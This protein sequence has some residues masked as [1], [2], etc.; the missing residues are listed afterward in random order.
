MELNMETCGFWMSL[1][2]TA[3]LMIIY[4]LGPGDG[5]LEL[6]PFDEES[7]PITI[8]TRPDLAIILRCDTVNHR[9]VST[10]N[11]YT[12]CLWV[13]APNA[14]GP[15]GW[16]SFSETALEK[17]EV[18]KELSA[19][20]EKR[21][22]ALMQKEA[23][24]GL[25]EDAPRSWLRWMRATYFK[26]SN[27][28]VAIT[29]AATH[30]PG[31]NTCE[32]L[33]KSVVNGVDYVQEVPFL[34]WNHGE[35]YDPDPD[36]WMQSHVCTGGI[37]KTCVRHHQFIDGVDLFD[38]K[39]FQISQSEATGME[40]MQRH[41][42]ET[43]YEALCMAG[44]TKKTLMNSYI[45]VFSGSTHPEAA[46][47]NYCT[48][49]G[50]GNISQAITSNR[51]SFV[52]GC[53][54]PSTSID[55]EMASSAMALM[56]G[57]SAVAPNNDWRTKSGGDS[58]AS[59][60]GGVYICVAGPFMWP[61]FHMYMSITGRSLTWDAKGN[62]YVRGECSMSVIQ[63]PYTEKLDGEWV[64]TGESVLGTIVGYRMTSNG[65]A[66]SMTA[67]NAPAY[68]EAVDE[69]MKAAGICPLDMDAVECHGVGS[70]LED[71]VEVSAL[72][73][74]LRSSAES[75]DE[76]L[77]LGAVKTNLS[78]ECEAS[79]IVAFVQVMYNIKFSANSGSLHLK[80]INPHMEGWESLQLST[81]SLPYRD[82]WAFHGA[83]SRGWGGVNT[84]IIQWYRVDENY[85]RLG[86]L[87]STRDPFAFWPGGGGV[88]KAEAKAMD[89]YHIVGSWNNWKPEE[90]EATDVG[91]F[92]YT[93]TLG[94]NRFE[95]FQIWLD[96]DSNRVL[97]PGRPRAPSALRVQGPV[98]LD[99][100]S[101]L[102]W[103]IDGRV[104]RESQAAPQGALTDAESSTGTTADAAADVVEY[105]T[106]DRG[107][108]GDQY[109]VKLSIA[110][111]YRA[112]VWRKVKTG[113]DDAEL[114]A[115]QGTYYVTGSFNEWGLSEMTLSEDVQLG[116]HTIKIGPLKQKRYEFQLVRNKAWDQ[117][118]YPTF[119]TIAAESWSEFEVD[120]PGDEGHGN[121]WCIKSRE[122][123][124]F[125]IEFQRSI[126]NGVDVKKISWRRVDE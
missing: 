121:N 94:M 83:S 85:V 93:V 22:E 109:E 40:P 68:Q 103:M 13:S 81:E 117:R 95:T 88:L 71:S 105:S 54:G 116:L 80:Q 65:R 10:G 70:Q 84:H 58:Q 97:H 74:L 45:A 126:G 16:N 102:N 38:N 15:R 7:E 20:A 2:F 111:K 27:L 91:I 67:P 115:L 60:T 49:A 63:K 72:G 96:G 79:G 43:S 82:E 92:T 26:H 76:P 125:L 28:P 12:L 123:D 29:G 59:I 30:G 52:L 64:V 106:R 90:M 39:L 44:Y 77:N 86:K 34:R 101:G 87:E 32:M 47:I 100:A 61:R 48:G 6:E 46:Y 35:Y 55:C 104:I 25:L 3:K 122:G 1:F 4:F 107:R 9:L 75:L 17:N 98:Q 108:V 21:L 51:T 42:L 57:C 73:R 62:G 89:A 18:L 8:P 118:F 31:S 19:W 114:R 112:V 11:D 23:E 119:S 113:A 41:I 24:T 78:A 36:C 53:M 37:T 99:E 56:V 14:A 66:A 120:G 110:G 5:K 50:A 69:A 33:W 124:F